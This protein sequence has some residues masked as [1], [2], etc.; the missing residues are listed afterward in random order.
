MLKKPRNLQHYT[1]RGE[2]LKSGLTL[3]LLHFLLRSC[4]QVNTIKIINARKT[5]EQERMWKETGVA[6]L[7]CCPTHLPE[8][9]EENHEG[10]NR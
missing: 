9:T 7:L 2:R 1:D 6:N 5:D 8:M 4:Q 10:R 3:I